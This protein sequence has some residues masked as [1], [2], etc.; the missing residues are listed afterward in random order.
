M[1]QIRIRAMVEQDIPSVARIYLENFKGMKSYDDVVRWMV[2]KHRSKPVC[3]YYIAMLGEEHVGYI[4]WTEHGG[5]RSNAVLELEQIAVAKR[6]QGRGIGGMLVVES[7]KDVCR[8]LHERGSELKLVIVT[9]SNS[10]TNA[11]RFYGKVL[12]AKEEAVLH[13]IYGSDELI[14][15]ARREEIPFLNTG[16]VE[17]HL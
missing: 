12:N 3:M 6:Y 2:M 16:L 1:V 7:L 9:T 8:Y 14:M 13:D 5:F 17:D 11:K 10:N 4:L 15:V